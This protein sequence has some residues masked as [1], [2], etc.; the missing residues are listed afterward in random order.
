M[1]NNLLCSHRQ[2]LNSG[3]GV[4]ALN[5]YLNCLSNEVLSFEFFKLVLE[6]E[7]FLSVGSQKWRM[8]RCRGLFRGEKNKADLQ[9]N[10]K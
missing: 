8:E 3:C 10:L 6:R 7:I 2:D 1:L 4:L 5:H 9:G